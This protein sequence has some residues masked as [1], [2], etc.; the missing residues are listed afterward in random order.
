M[1]VFMPARRFFGRNCQEGNVTFP[2]QSLRV[3]PSP[4]EIAGELRLAIAVNSAG[5]AYVTGYSW[6]VGGSFAASDCATIAYS[7]TG[8]ALWTNRYNGPANS[9]DSGTAIVLDS[10]GNVFVTGNSSG[11][12]SDIDVATIKYSSGGMPLWTNRYNGSENGHD[13]AAAIAIDHSGNVFVT[14]NSGSNKATLAYSNAGVP[15]WTNRYHGPNGDSSYVDF[16]IAMAADRIGNVFITGQSW[17]SGTQYDWVTIK[18][19]SSNPVPRLDFQK[20]N[21]QLVLKWTNADFTLQSA[22]TTTGTFTNIPTATSPY[23]NSLTAPLQF[24]RLV[25]NW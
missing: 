8:A 23:T 10:T 19:S 15:L 24:F 14:G 6:D 2:A 20:L 9:T 16:A 7:D 25:S 17:N 11:I 22:P 4:R 12:N 1:R 5:T 3:A 13:S 18:Y 21:Y